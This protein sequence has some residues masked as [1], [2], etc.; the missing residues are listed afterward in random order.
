MQIAAAA[1]WMKAKEY[2]PDLLPEALTSFHQHLVATNIHLPKDK[3]HLKVFLAKHP[4]SAPLQTALESIFEGLKN[5][6]ELGSLVQIEEPVEKELRYLRQ[7]FESTQKHGI[8]ANLFEP[9]VIQGELPLGVESYE[10]WKANTLIHLGRH[11]FE[12]VESS[13]PIQRFFGQSVRKGLSLFDILARQFNII[14]ANPPY[15]GATN[16]DDV[17]KPYITSTYSYSKWDLY[18]VFIVRC[19]SLLKIGGRTAMVTINKWLFFS[20][21]S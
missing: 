21:L 10:E 7:K 14:T 8:Q 1:L 18:A 11:F 2:A 20:A 6:H 3:D 19:L 5:V 16:M 12:E 4:E 15:M 9:T 17:L 13:D